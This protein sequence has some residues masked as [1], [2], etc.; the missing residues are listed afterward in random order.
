M[1]PPELWQ[2][3]EAAAHEYERYTAPRL[4]DPWVPEL[5]AAVTLRRDERVLDVACGTGLV[6]RSA[7]R[8]VGERGA[9]VGVDLH[10]PML[11]VARATPPMRGAA[12]I[13]WR[14]GDAGALP[15]ADASFDVVLCQQGLQFFADRKAALAE[16]RRALAPLGRVGIVVW[17]GIARNPYFQALAD[18]VE[19]RLGPEAGERLRSPFV[20]GEAD[21]LRKLLAGA[22]FDPARVRP[23]AKAIL[24]PPLTEFVPRHL[25]ST[26]LASEVAALGGTER[27]AAVDE[28][29]TALRPFARGGGVRA[30]FEV[31]VAAGQAPGV[32]A[33]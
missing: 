18:A 5:L 13:D 21:E 27:R 33:A 11:A 30:P 26:S 19:R 4:L 29:A 22:G 24:L 23:Q 25:A 32:P 6:T 8:V 7:A 9:V 1:K 16:M 28:I 17:G 15:V 31:L 2:R 12:P 10:P 14:D 20:L 3:D